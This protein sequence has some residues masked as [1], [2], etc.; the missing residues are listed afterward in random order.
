MKIENN[1]R[2]KHLL[3]S[4]LSIGDCFMAPKKMGS[5]EVFIIYD[6]PKVGTEIWCISLC[7]GTGKYFGMKDECTK[8]ECHLV[9]DD[10]V[11]YK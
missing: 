7:N 5:A 9:V 4:D 10:L 3:M 8:V 6:K 11:E 2:K 1:V